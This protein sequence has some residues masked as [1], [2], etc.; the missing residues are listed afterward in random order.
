MKTYKRDECV[1]FWRT[2]EAFGGL[3]NMCAG[4]PIEVYA[5]TELIKV[6]TTEAL[7]Q[8]LRFPS[9]PDIQR[10]VIS[11]KSPMTAKMVTKPHRADKCRPDWDEVKLPI[12]YWC[13][14]L[15]LAQHWDSFRALL[16]STAGK[17]IVEFSRKDNWW[18]AMPLDDDWGVVRG[19]NNLGRL[20]DR[21]RDKTTTR[22]KSVPVPNLSGMILYGKPL[23]DYTVRAGEG[24]SYEPLF[25]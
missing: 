11:Q 19:H 21:L 9:H 14:Q 7:Y 5:G 20:L 4:Y 17:P 23:Q 2:R 16:D 3:S 10:N 1:F 8:A 15:K 13:N 6:R 25:G 12:M 18:G 22:P 24:D